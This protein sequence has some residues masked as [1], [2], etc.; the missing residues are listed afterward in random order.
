M[1]LDKP[2]RWH[3]GLDTMWKR[4]NA[5]HVSRK[6]FKGKFGL[7]LV[8]RACHILPGFVDEASVL[9]LL[10]LATQGDESGPQ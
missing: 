8:Y 5:S 4:L 6:A 10:R 7:S 9:E 3:G 2:Q 1:R